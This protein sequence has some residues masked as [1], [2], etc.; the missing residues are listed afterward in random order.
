MLLADPRH[1]PGHV[2]EG[3]QRDVEAVAR[4][5]ESRCLGRRID[6]ERAGEDRGLLRDDTDAAT[7]E[8]SEPV[9]MFGAQPGWISR[10]PP[11]STTAR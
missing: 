5:D 8:P 1:E 2:D 9:M 11:S 7:A 10:N 3:Q 4:P 6:V